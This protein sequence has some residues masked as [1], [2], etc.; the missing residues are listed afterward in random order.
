MMDLEKLKCCAE[1]L[2]YELEIV[3]ISER[4]TR[5]DY[6][7][8]GEWLGE[9]DPEHNDAQAF[10]LLKLLFE[11]AKRGEIDIWTVLGDIHVA[12]NFAPD[13]NEGQTLNQSVIEAVW[14][15]KK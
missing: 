11:M 14:E 5:V 1:A 15:V 6:F 10:E 3:K 9:Y 8:D 7:K 12:V 13:Y 2:G 4:R